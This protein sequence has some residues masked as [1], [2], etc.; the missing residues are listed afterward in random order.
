MASLE[1]T[2]GVVERLTRRGCQAVLPQSHVGC[3]SNL[4]ESGATPWLDHTSICMTRLFGDLYRY[5]SLVQR[6]KTIRRSSLDDAGM[7][8]PL[9]DV[10]TCGSANAYLNGWIKPSEACAGTKDEGFVR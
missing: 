2:S 9:I 1:S 6:S 10:V 5:S 8:I 7:P 4:W 3:L